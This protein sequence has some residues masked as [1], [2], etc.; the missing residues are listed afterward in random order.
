[1]GSGRPGVTIC[2][3]T[4][5]KVHL[6]LISARSLAR[7]TK[8][9]SCDERAV[10]EWKRLLGFPLGGTQRLLADARTPLDPRR[11]PNPARRDEPDRRRTRAR[12]VAGPTRV[13]GPPDDLPDRRVGHQ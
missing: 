1:A 11:R 3:G 13:T 2:L 9:G 7:E 5:H 12:P 4:S 6:L 8:T 10:H